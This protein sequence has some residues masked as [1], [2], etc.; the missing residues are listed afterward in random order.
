MKIVKSVQELY[1][2]H[3]AYFEI[4]KQ[5]ADDLIKTNKNERWHYESRI[6]QIE[7]FAMKVEMARFDKNE[8]LEDFFAST[9]VVKNLNEIA[10]AENFISRFF[11]IRFKRPSSRNFT[12]K[13][14]FSFPFD[15]LRLYV[16]IKDL[17]TGEFVP[18]MYEYIFE[19]QVKTFLQHAWS[20]ATHDLIYKSD[21]INWAKERI[22]YQV[23]ASLEQAEVTISGVEELSKI[24]ELA[25]DNKEVQKVNKV[26]NLILNHWKPDDLPSDRRRL[27]QNI[28]GFIDAIGIDLRELNE[29]LELEKVNGRGTLTRNLSPFLIVVQSVFNTKP[30]KI[31]NYLQNENNKSK[32]KILITSEMTVPELGQV[33]ENK[34]IRL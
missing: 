26:I 1:N 30:D 22:A 11:T 12:H 15:D 8:I 13:D 18:F 29:I 14:S 4:I 21:K 27:A 5:K 24:N 17:D 28:T 7:S 9:I 25:K 32:Q 20:I 31:T 2:S 23:K 19:I 16:S 33:I 3:L 6:K 10:F 34:L